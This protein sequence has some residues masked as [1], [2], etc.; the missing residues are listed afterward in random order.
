M[1]GGKRQLALMQNPD[2][3]GPKRRNKIFSEDFIIARQFNSVY[4]KLENNKIALLLMGKD[5][6][7]EEERQ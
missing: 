7:D 1:L 3:A 6:Q 2:Y 5:S 4:N